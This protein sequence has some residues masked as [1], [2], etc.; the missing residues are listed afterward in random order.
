MLL[1][2]SASAKTRARPVFKLFPIQKIRTIKKTKV[3][4]LKI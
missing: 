3:K 4:D 2:N 1:E